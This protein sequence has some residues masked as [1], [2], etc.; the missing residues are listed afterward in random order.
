MK[1]E[2]PLLHL[3]PID[4]GAA[5]GARCK[6]RGRGRTGARERVRELL[7]QVQPRATPGTAGNRETG[8][9]YANLTT[10]NFIRNCS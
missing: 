5:C 1:P 6:S 9:C 2:H 10:R 3:R 7:R 8:P 4:R